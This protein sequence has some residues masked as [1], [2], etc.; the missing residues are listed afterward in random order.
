MPLCSPYFD[1]L[2]QPVQDQGGGHNS[3]LH[4]DRAYTLDLDLLGGGD[5]SESSHL[6]LQKI[7]S[8]ISLLYQSDAYSRDGLMDRLSRVMLDLAEAGNRLADTVVDVTNDG[9]GL[10]AIRAA[11]DCAA[12]VANKM[13]VRTGAYNPLGFP[14]NSSGRWQL[15]EQGAKEAD[16]IGALPERN[17]RSDYPDHI[18]FEEYCV[19]VIDLGRRLGKFLHIHTDQQNG[20]LRMPPSGWS[21]LSVGKATWCPRT[22]SK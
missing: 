3:Q 10:T 22:A 16:F 9:V 8:L 11:N 12:K 19:R 4:L 18:G 13:K 21:K 1:R 20:H 7:H 2:R 15:I 5:I 6:P 14:A 17:Q